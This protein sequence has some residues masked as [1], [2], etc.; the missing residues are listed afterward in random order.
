MNTNSPAVTAVRVIAPL[1]VIAVSVGIYAALGPAKPVPKASGKRDMTALVETV[2]VGDAVAGFDVDVDGVVVPYRE[3]TVSAEVAGRVA[4]KDPHCKAGRVVEAGQLLVEIDSRDYEI[5]V[6]R[7]STDVEQAQVSI[8]ET[9]VEIKNTEL[10]ID[11]AA[12]DLEIER[13]EL[14]RVM[15]L[16]DDDILTDSERDQSKRAELATQT[17]LQTLHNRKQLLSTQRTRLERMKKLAESRL[18]K[19]RLDLDRTKIYC[20][21]DGIVVNDA[22]EQDAYVQPGAAVV[23]IEDTSSVEVRVSLHSDQL[24]WLW[25]TPDAAASEL[26][27]T[28]EVSAASLPETADG[29]QD[30]YRPYRLPKLPVT[31]SYYVE[32]REFRWDGVLARYDGPGFDERTRMVPCRIVVPDPR[33]A[34][35]IEPDGS[36]GPREP[37][38]LVRGMYV[39]ARIHAA[40]DVHLIAVPENAI[41]PGGVVWTVRDGKLAIRHVEIAKFADDVAYVDAEASDLSTGDEVIISPLTVSVDGMA[42]EVRNG[43]GDTAAIEPASSHATQVANTRGDSAQVPAAEHPLAVDTPA[44]QASDGGTSQQGAQ[45]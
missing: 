1:A 8:D 35:V 12:E 38:A 31:V 27:D 43:W 30:P 2:R 34:T 45:P 37:R 26:P 19:A 17:S 33:E 3:V 23:T 29:P 28:S 16:A 14:A 5:E 40:P 24:Q 10:L 9:D 36:S 21:F 32:G 7:L 22:V 15:Q 41:R 4:F 11:I 39:R 13:Q 44:E 18:Q 42:V 20:P 6:E 25:S